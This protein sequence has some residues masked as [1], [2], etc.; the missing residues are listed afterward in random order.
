MRIITIMMGTLFSV[1]GIYLI[2]NGGLTFMSVAFIVGL[3]FAVAGV[4]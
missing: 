3:M 4:I 2:A 1:T